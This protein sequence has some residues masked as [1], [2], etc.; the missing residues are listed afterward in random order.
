MLLLWQH[1]Q[2][3]IVRRL[4]NMTVS[5]AVSAEFVVRKLSTVVYPYHL[6]TVSLGSDHR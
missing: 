5:P 1:L 3:L 2:Q 6:Q 4:T